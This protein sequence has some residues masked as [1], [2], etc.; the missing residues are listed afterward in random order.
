MFQMKNFFIKDDLYNYYIN[1][2]NVIM[3]KFQ[4][5]PKTIWL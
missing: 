4:K 1:V 5:N 3:D 2:S